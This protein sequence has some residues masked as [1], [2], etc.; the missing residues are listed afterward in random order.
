VERYAQIFLLEFLDDFIKIED[1]ILASVSKRCIWYFFLNYSIK[2]R[3]RGCIKKEHL[4]TLQYVKIMLTWPCALKIQNPP[5]PPDQL[6]TM[7]ITY[8]E[9]P[10]R[11][12]W[13]AH[14]V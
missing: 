1:E 11:R 14:P 5:P 13:S 2:V 7:K 12:N 9:T 3:Q 6:V 8:L 4:K 10:S